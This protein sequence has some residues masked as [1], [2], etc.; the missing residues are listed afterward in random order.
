[1]TSRL[2]RAQTFAMPTRDELTGTIRQRTSRRSAPAQISFALTCAVLIAACAPNPPI[3][4]PQAV[5]V[6]RTVAPVCKL[7]GCC[8]GHGDVA[9]LQSDLIVMCTDGEPSRICDCH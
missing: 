8:V 9:Y 1:M 4:S 2:C 6:R 5:P 3:A 7:Q